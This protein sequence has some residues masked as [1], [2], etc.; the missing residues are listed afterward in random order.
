M[1]SIQ[2]AIDVHNDSSYAITWKMAVNALPEQEKL[3]WDDEMKNEPYYCPFAFLRT[4]KRMGINQQSTIFQE[5]IDR[6]RKVK[7]NREHQK[8]CTA[9]K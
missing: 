8:V 3:F 7:P 6:V 2:L 5:A 1:T 4:L 9:R